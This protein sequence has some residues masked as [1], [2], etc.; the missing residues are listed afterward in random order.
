M[1]VP[2]ANVGSPKVRIMECVPRR[3]RIKLLPVSAGRRAVEPRRVAS[4][5]RAPYAPVLRVEGREV[6]ARRHS[7]LPSVHSWNG[8]RR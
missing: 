1:V 4:D 5:A 2:L 6:G 3:D 8:R 7:G